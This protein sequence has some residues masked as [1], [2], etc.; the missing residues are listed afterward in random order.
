MTRPRAFTLI[1]VMLVLLILSLL[2]TVPITWPVAGF[3]TSMVL[4]AAAS[5]H[6]LSIN[7]CVWG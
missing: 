2:T 7:S 5:T 3:S 1:E 6:W 4:P